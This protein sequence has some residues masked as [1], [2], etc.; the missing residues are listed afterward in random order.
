VTALAS[1]FGDERLDADLSSILGLEDE[2]ARKALLGS[3]NTQDSGESLRLS[4]RASVTIAASLGFAVIAS[5][6]L[7]LR[8]H[9]PTKTSSVAA[10]P[11]PDR[12]AVGRGA[13]LQPAVEGP[14]PVLAA[15][16]DEDQNSEAPRVTQQ[17]GK[18][19]PALNADA[20]SRQPAITELASTSSAVS[21]STRPANKDDPAEGH[22]QSATLL[23]LNENPASP[24]AAMPINE[25]RS[26]V[27]PDTLEPTEPSLRLKK[28][29]RGSIE[30]IRF[31]RRQ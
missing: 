25:S 5:T 29:R 21:S 2:R 12:L 30:A 24:T 20:M 15:V 11:I 9:I 26:V 16:P 3:K 6:A 17:Q 10:V 14:K 19:S 7:L 23:A 28:A 1:P 8:D 4:R 13:K 18:Q 22:V 31:L 27:H